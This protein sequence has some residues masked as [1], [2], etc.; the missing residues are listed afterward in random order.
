MRAATNWELIKFRYEVRGESLSSLAKTFGVSEDVVKFNAKKWKQVPFIKE[1]Q[2][3]F[4]DA[5][6]LEDVM[7]ILERAVR[8][9]ARVAVLIKQK[10]LTSKY[11]ELETLILEKL[12]VLLES[13]E[14]TQDAQA[15]AATLKSLSSTFAELLSKNRHLETMPVIDAESD[16]IDRTWNVEVTHVKKAIGDA[17]TN[18]HK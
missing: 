6:N 3:T 8:N 11:I 13:V 14:D 1:A 10:F 16:G 2:L 17:K 9:D 15:A 12:G 18:N 5:K 7:G 4:K